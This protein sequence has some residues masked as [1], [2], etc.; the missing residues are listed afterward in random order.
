MTGK[1]YYVYYPT[2][3]KPPLSTPSTPQPPNQPQRPTPPSTAPGIPSPLAPPAASPTEP[4]APRTDAT[5]ALSSAESHVASK[6][7][8]VWGRDL[9]EMVETTEGRIV[10]A[11]YFFIESG[12]TSIQ[13]AALVGNMAYESTDFRA[14]GSP[15][16]V[17]SLG[18]IGGGGGI[19][20]AQWTYQPR[21]N[22]LFALAKAMGLPW[23]NLGVQLSYVWQELTTDYSSAFS[24]LRRATSLQSATQII[25]QRYE[26]NADS[27]NAGPTAP[28]SASYWGR[29]AE[30]QSIY[31]RFR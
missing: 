3:P 5:R 13:A 16:L 25:E 8:D 18:Q 12:L 1:G 2:P 10:L 26:Q 23:D 4:F 20:I 31:A 22:G 17:P 7:G 28:K 21:K 27:G 9:S 29:L 6:G 30:A 19:G 11:Y 15:K 24:A 14:K